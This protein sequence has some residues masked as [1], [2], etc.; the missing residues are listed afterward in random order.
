[1]SF[2]ALESL[3]LEATAHAG[4]LFGT[5]VGGIGV[6]VL[7]GP[8]IGCDGVRAQRSKEVDSIVALEGHFDIQFVAVGIV[9]ADGFAADSLGKGTTDSNFD[10][11]RSGARE[12]GQGGNARTG[13]GG[14]EVADEDILR[15]VGGIG[16][17]TDL[18][19][20]GTIYNGDRPAGI[21]EHER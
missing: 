11:G 4:I 9:E 18:A 20:A 10:L 8:I 1:M 16:I 7:T 19:V 13:T 6:G 21:L 14:L 2:V 5:I 3:D 17:E 15:Q 12:T